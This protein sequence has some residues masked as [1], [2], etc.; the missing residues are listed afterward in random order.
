MGKIISLQR[1]KEERWARP[2]GH[3]PLRRGPRGKALL[4]RNQVWVE[5]CTDKFWVIMDYK[6]GLQCGTY[7]HRI[8]LR[9]YDARERFQ[10][11]R[12]RELAELTLRATMRVWEDA[13]A[14]NPLLAEKLGGTE[15]P[16]EAA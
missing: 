13:L 16:P 7:T 14:S 3:P 6:D 10:E 11:R 4:D 15:P 2:V 9:P 5:E 1:F 12:S 8:W